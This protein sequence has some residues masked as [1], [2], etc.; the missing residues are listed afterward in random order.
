L[1]SQL[2]FTVFHQ[3]AILL[4]LNVLDLMCSFW[5][6]RAGV[7]VEANPIM[8]YIYQ[9]NPWVFVLAKLIIPTTL[10]LLVNWLIKLVRP[11]ILVKTLMNMTL[12]VYGL[13]AVTHI[14]IIVKYV[15]SS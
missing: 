12:V 14:S 10:L 13:I 9:V 8:N 6:L 4:V 1:K 11:S 3:I 2:K 7:I 5:G 15:L